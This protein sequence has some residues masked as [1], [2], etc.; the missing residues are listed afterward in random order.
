MPESTS[1]SAVGKGRFGTFG[2]V[3]VPNVLTILGLIYFLRTG[4]VVGQLGLAQALIVVAIANVISLLTGLSLSEVSTPMTVRTGGA[5]F[6]L[7]RTLGL[8]VGGAIGIPLFVSQAVSVAF[9]VIGFTTVLQA[10]IPG[11][12][13]YAPMLSTGIVLGF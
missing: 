8:E 7:T 6:I 2:G 5:Y 10:V 1:T 12:A 3:F 11:I 13:P 4:W 9:Y